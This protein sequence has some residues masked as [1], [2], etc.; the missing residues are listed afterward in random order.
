V[1][2]RHPDGRVDEDSKATGTFVAADSVWETYSGGGGGVGNPNER[3]VSFIEADLAD[4]YITPAFAEK[5]YPQ[6]KNEA[7]GS[8][9]KAD[10]QAQISEEGVPA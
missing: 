7:A 1:L 2:I 10:A 3:A 9:A 5:W 8:R 6:Y 4:G